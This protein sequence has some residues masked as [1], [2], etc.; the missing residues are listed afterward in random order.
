[1]IGQVDDLPGPGVELIAVLEVL[2]QS[3]AH[4]QPVGG[5]NGEVSVV[6]QGVDVRPEQPSL[7][8]ERRWQLTNQRPVAAR[9]ARG[10]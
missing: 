10:R 7:N 5:I 2:A 6:E 3:W 8:P 4:E 9:A 1:V